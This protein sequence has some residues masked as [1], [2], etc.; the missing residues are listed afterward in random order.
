M[1]DLAALLSSVTAVPH[2]PRHN[3]PA[4]P[5][6]TAADYGQGYNDHSTSDKWMALL[7]GLI[8]SLAPLAQRIM[9]G[10]AAQNSMM[11]EHY[12]GDALAKLMGGGDAPAP[13]ASAAAPAPQQ[14]RDA[15]PLASLT[16]QESPAK[17]DA[18]PQGAMAYFA[19]KYGKVVG[20]AIA[21][22]FGPESAGWNPKAFNPSGGGQGAF[23]LGQ[24][25]GSRLRDLKA[26]AAQQ[27]RDVSDPEVQYAFADQELNTTHSGVL[28]ALQNV[29]DPA[30]AALIF[31]QTYERPG[32]V[33]QHY[34]DRIAREGRQAMEGFVPGPPAPPNSAGPDVQ[35]AAANAA[36][37]A[38]EVPAQQ[39]A[40][41]EALLHASPQEV[42]AFRA[43]YA[44]PAT[45]DAA[46]KY[47]TKLIQDNASPSYEASVNGDQVIHYSKD[48]RLGAQVENIEGVHPAPPSGMMY[49]PRNPS[50][51]VPIPGTEI[52][53]AQ[54]VNG[55]VG[56][57]QRGPNGKL[58]R[59]GDE[60]YGGGLPAGGAK[61]DPTLPPGAYRKPGVPGVWINNPARKP[62]LLLNDGQT[63]AGPTGDPTKTGVDYLKSLPKAQAQQVQLLAEGR[64]PFPTGFAL[65]SPYWQN[66]LQAVGQ[67]DPNF[68]A[69]NYNARSK[70]RN[71]ATS[72]KMAGDIK[73]LNTAIGHM[74]QLSR[75]IDGLGN[76]SFTP[77]NAV[78][79]FIANKTG[80]PRVKKFE[81]DRNAVVA[82]T[83]RVFR[84]GVGSAGDINE[85]TDKLNAADSPKQLHAVVSELAGLL[86]SR[87][88]A[89][90]EQYSKGMG[91][92]TDPF[93]LLNPHAAEVFKQLRAGGTVS[94]PAQSAPGSK[95]AHKMTDD[96]LRA[97]LGL[98]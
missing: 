96:E 93:T 52:G 21:G 69:V 11:A 9:Q 68:D 87:L 75:S 48:P 92:T 41:R 25:R 10:H 76:Y 43:M 61:Q 24:W 46:V 37:A 47:A 6:A 13:Q 3:A 55:A 51:V 84:G 23:G 31:S 60:A 49:D 30:Q 89:V 14:T 27:G 94:A 59:I 80:D 91:T 78:A 32:N 77:N 4:M 56:V 85:W 19:P 28:R 88:Q 42:A 33:P 34:R 57:F 81:T 64:M 54:Q 29:Q 50:H 7:G 79:N 62:E 39:S 58:D 16:G 5:K 1:T 97:A 40:A 90:G 38:A 82:E 70:T 66:M 17:F 74:G 95:P 26:F 63:S 83:V 72:G 2:L 65:R 36:P 98:H 73:A 45:R 22:N 20:A 8:P 18:S 71:D 86:D 35:A 67:Y 44:N 53:P 15:D 12:Q